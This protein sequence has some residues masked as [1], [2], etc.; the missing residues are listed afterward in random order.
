MV[1]QHMAR[2]SVLEAQK[3]RIEPVPIK[4]TSC[5]RILIDSCVIIEMLQDPEFQNNLFKLFDGTTRP[6]VV[7]KCLFE[8]QKV[9]GWKVNTIKD[10]LSRIFGQK[11]HTIRTT[12]PIE[13]MEYS[14]RF[15]Y[16]GE[17]HSADSTLLALGVRLDWQVCTKDGGLIRLCKKEN[18][19]AIH[20]KSNGFTFQG[21]LK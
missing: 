16:P 10:V 15:K 19:K 11:I 21:E 7:D 1:V 20:P 4:D 2:F 5:K 9:T 18:V 14:M 17:S 12:K 3:L 8:V 13:Q 6:V